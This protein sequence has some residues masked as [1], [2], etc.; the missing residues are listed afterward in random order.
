[1]PT[2]SSHRP[3]YTR[4]KFFVYLFVALIV[5]AYGWRVTGIDPAALVKDF[6]LVKPLVTALLQPDLITR[7]TEQQTVEARFH[8]AETTGEESALTAPAHK[9]PTLHLSR[10]RGQI[11]DTLTVA[12]FHLQPERTGK[13]YWVNAIEQEYP[14]GE[15]TTDAGGH[16][17]KAVTVPPTA[18]GDR[19]FLRVVLEWETGAWHISETLKLTADKIVE[20]LFLGLMATTFALILA[21][22][23]SF[24][25]ARNLM[26]R[27]W[28]GTTIYYLVRTGFNVLR[29]IEPLIM[30]IL[31]AVWVGIGPFAG[32]L[33]LALHSTAAL[34][35]LFS[36]QIESIDPGPVEAITATGARPMQVVLYGVLP[37]VVPQF[38]ALGFYRWDIN[39]RMSTII[40]FVGGGGIGFLL[41]QWI[42]LLQYNQAGTA[43]LAI[44]LVV[45]SLDLV[46]AKVREKIT[47]AS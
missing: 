28:P 13:L 38:L 40:G 12:G 22:P 37:Q 45:I 20:T 27:H 2:P 36:E 18:R 47:L 11:G 7:D 17:E 24:L 33:A 25:G 15:V 6:H 10:L 1:M 29:A 46:S 21:L 41:Q 26:T 42:N 31:L 16:F 34:G 8:V 9:K 4:T 44:A 3:F 14:L 30:A 43:L 19:Q 23:L 5:Y 32:V 39:V 35:K